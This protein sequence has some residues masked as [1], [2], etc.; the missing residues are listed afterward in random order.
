[1]ILWLHLKEWTWIC[2]YKVNA[3]DRTDV[4][5]CDLIC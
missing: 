5:L 2:M 4:C 1:M 3:S